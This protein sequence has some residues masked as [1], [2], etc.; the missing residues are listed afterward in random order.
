MLNRKRGEISGGVF[1]QCNYSPAIKMD[2]PELHLSARLELT[3]ACIWLCRH[4]GKEMG[5]VVSDCEKC[6][7]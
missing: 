3:K 5:M 4:S 7:G 1:T 6:Q 2:G